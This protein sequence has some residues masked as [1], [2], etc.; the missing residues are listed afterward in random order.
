[1][2]K[3]MIMVRDMVKEKLFYLMVMF[4]KGFIFMERGMGR[5]GF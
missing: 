3:E 5:Y 2:G 1:M 4:M